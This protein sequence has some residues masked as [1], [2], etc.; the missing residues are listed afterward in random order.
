M[1]LKELFFLKSRA[2][3]VRGGGVGAVHILHVTTIV[4]MPLESE[5]GIGEGQFN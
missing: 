5:P 3:S 2:D 4:L 1:T